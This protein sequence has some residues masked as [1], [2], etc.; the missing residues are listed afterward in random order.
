MLLLSRGGSHNTFKNENIKIFTRVD[1][2]VLRKSQKIMQGN[3]VDTRKITKK[4]IMRITFSFYSGNEKEKLLY[5]SKRKIQDCLGH[6][7]LNNL[8]LLCFHSP[9]QV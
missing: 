9:Y 5:T 7:N 2:A 6:F 3:A 1:D 4:F 8:S